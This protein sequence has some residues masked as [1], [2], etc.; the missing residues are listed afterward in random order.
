MYIE[1]NTL[2]KST[3]IYVASG[4]FKVFL[5]R[6]DGLSES[7][8][9]WINFSEKLFWFFYKNFLNFRSDTIKMK[10]IINLSDNSIKSY[11]ILVLTDFKVAIWK[12]GEDS[13]FRFLF[14]VFYL[15]KVLHNRSGIL[16]NLL[17]FMWHFAKVC[18]FSAFIFFSIASRSSP[19]NNF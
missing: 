4:F 8:T 14:I 13:A 6:L 15:F 2:E 12:K 7:V 1:S 9:F 16:S 11:A 19:I 18:S 10:G 3:N 17:V 5:Q